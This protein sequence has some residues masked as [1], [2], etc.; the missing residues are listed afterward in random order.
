MVNM[1]QLN[2]PDA[3]SDI[4]KQTRDIAAV[5]VKAGCLTDLFGAVRRIPAVITPSAG[6][7]QKPFFQKLFRFVS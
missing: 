4:V 7:L 3:S 1:R 2:I 5:F 6:V